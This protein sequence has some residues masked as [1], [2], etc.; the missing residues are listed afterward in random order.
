MLD[1]FMHRFRYVD[2]SN[3]KEY[4]NRGDVSIDFQFIKKT[5][6]VFIR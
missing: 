5:N 1:I 3:R 2:N 6:V 4:V